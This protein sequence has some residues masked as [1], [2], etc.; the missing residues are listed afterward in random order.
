MKSIMKKIALILTLSLV[1]GVS[2][3]TFYSE[4]QVDCSTYGDQNIGNLIGY[5]IASNLPSDSNKI[6]MSSTDDEWTSGE[7]YAVQ[8]NREL[9]FFSGRGWNEELG[10][11]D[12]D[13]GTEDQ[14]D[15]VS[16]DG[17]FAWGGYDGNIVGL[18]TITYSNN[19]GSFSAGSAYDT[20]YVSGQSDGD[21]QV[22]MGELDFSN[23][24][25]DTSETIPEE[26]REKVDVFVNGRSTA[27]IGICNQTAT[28]AWNSNQ[29]SNC[30]TTGSAPWGSTGSKADS[31]SETSGTISSGD[32]PAYFRL[33]CTGDIT[34]NM[35]TGV[36]KAT[37]GNIDCPECTSVEDNNNF[38]FIES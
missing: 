16:P 13:F 33:E 38:E 10:W 29:V 11:I 32:S 34:G 35:I 9:A 36:A 28:I 23:V 19:N 20:E 2:T 12:F 8:Y 3:P 37:C 14:A 21:V 25:F 30:Q 24:L 4:A 22:G 31:G 5:A 17:S 26:C 6:Y 27:D 7:D 15:A 18:K 1:V